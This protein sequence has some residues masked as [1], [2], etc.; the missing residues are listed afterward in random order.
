LQIDEI[1]AALDIITDQTLRLLLLKRQNALADQIGD[2]Y[3]RTERIE[4]RPD[5]DT[6]DTI[7]QAILHRDKHRCRLCGRSDRTLHVHHLLELSRG[8]RTE[9]SNLLTLCQD[10]HAIL[11][12]WLNAP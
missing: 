2:A 1:T 12:P 7:R 11:H 4:E 6:W 3:A 5:A 9:P 10:C 8:G